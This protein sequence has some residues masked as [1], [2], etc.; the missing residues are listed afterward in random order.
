MSNRPEKTGVPLLAILGGALVCASACRCGSTP[1]AS[2]DGSADAATADAATS[3]APPLFATRF[4]GAQNQWAWSVATD[5][6]GDVVIAGDFEGTFDL[7]GGPLVSAGGIDVFVVK[8]G[9]DGAHKWSRRFGSEGD[10]RVD[11]IA[12]DASGNIGL[13]GSFSGSLDFGGGALTSARGADAFFA[14]LDGQGNHLW[15]KSAGSPDTE[16]DGMAVAFD[17]AG[18]LSV[19][20][21]AVGPID[22]G[23]VVAPAEGEKSLFVARLDSA[24]KYLWSKRIG[25]DHEQIGFAVASDAAGATYVTGRFEKT[26]DLGG[27]PITAGLREAFVAK[28]DAKGAH[29]FSRRLGDATAVGLADGR[30]VVADATGGVFV[31]GS[32]SGSLDLGTETLRSAGDTDIFVVKLD[33]AG[34]VVWGKRFG[35]AS[36]QTAT[37]L[38][39]GPSGHLQVG[40]SFSGTLELGP[41]RLSARDN[42]AFFAE[43]D[44]AG[45]P[46]RAVQLGGPGIQEVTSLAVGRGGAT[47]IV[48]SFDNA[49]D[50]GRGVVASAG[51]RD[52]FLVSLAPPG[53]R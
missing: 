15:S 10:Q 22:L 27:G 3:T 19:T 35:D 9:P 39:L 51:G 1:A 21:S 29:V 32:F 37:S 25:N 34:A 44:G 52:A 33:A 13:T 38:A 41:S 18:N 12:V 4:G 45:T 50:L 16:E 46:L 40:G 49:I 17:G 53:T 24:G 23:G 42:D 14:K 28:Y 2:A 47:W 31:A 30:A 36:F 11:G 48:G 5:P 7:G 6:A 26:I 8:L 43:L 20:G